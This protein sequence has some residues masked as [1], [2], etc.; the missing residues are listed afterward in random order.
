MHTQNYTIQLAKREL[1]DRFKEIEQ[2]FEDNQAAVTLRVLCEA[3]GI[4]TC[5]LKFV[6]PDVRNITRYPDELHRGYVR[7]WELPDGRGY[8]I[9]PDRGNF[10]DPALFWQTVE[11]IMIDLGSEHKCKLS[12]SLR[13]SVPHIDP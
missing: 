7:A 1:W 8:E 9:K 4:I 11:S 6:P 3:G 13:K 5:I 2:R 10:P 12:T